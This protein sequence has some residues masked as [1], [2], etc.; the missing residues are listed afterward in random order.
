M[1]DTPISGL[2]ART[3]LTL[4]DEL[5]TLA[6]GINYRS[7]VSALI[8][9]MPTS[10]GGG[11]G[12][13]T[14]TASAYF[15]SI[16]AVLAAT[17]PATVKTIATSGYD[18][19]GV[20]GA[21]YQR[22]AT[23]P[24]LLAPPSNALAASAPSGGHYPSPH[25]LSGINRGILRSVDRFLPNGTSDPDKGGWWMLDLQQGLTPQMFGAW[26][27]YT[28]DDG[29]AIKDAHEFCWVARGND[30]STTTPVT[31]YIPLRFPV[32]RYNIA[33]TG[34][35][36]PLHDHMVW[37][38]EGTYGD[39]SSFVSQVRFSGNDMFV[40]TPPLTSP[41]RNYNDWVTFIGMG[42]DGKTQAFN[43]LRR[44][45]ITNPSDFI[46]FHSTFEKCGFKNF[47]YAFEALLSGVMI[48]YC[49]FQNCRCGLK[50]A[51]ADNIIEN[52]YMSGSNWDPVTGNSNSDTATLDPAG[53]DTFAVIFGSFRLSRFNRNYITGRPQMHLGVQGSLDGTIL[54]QNW[55]DI[56]DWSAVVLERSKGGVFIG[57]TFNNAML[58]DSAPLA[59]G[60][61][62]PPWPL[63]GPDMSKSHKRD[64]D[65][66]YNAII[67][68]TNNSH[69]HVFANNSFSYLQAVG[70]DKLPNG[71]HSPLTLK[72]TG[73]T[74]VSDGISHPGKSNNI[75]FVG[76]NFLSNY[77]FSMIY[78]T[79]SGP[80][81]IMERG[82]T[83]DTGHFPYQR[84]HA[85][86]YTD[87][88]APFGLVGAAG[89]PAG[90]GVFVGE[91]SGTGADITNITSW[92]VSNP[93][94]VR[95]QLGTTAA[96]FA[97]I[98]TGTNVIQFTG[99]EARCYFVFLE[100]I[101]SVPATNT[102]VLRLGFLD[103]VTGVPTDG[104]FFRYQ[105]GVN[106][107]KW[108]AVCLA[109]GAETVED[110]GIL[111]GSGNKIRRFQVLVDD[112][113]QWASFYNSDSLVAGIKAP[114]PG[115]ASPPAAMTNIPSGAGGRELGVGIGCVKLAGG[116]PTSPVD[117][118]M[119]EFEQRLL[120]QR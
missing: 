96:G 75:K 88:L 84:T 94:V 81:I 89:A 19:L 29:P 7:P 36:I 61:T 26:A 105:F 73:G 114:I 50:C 111:W 99:G 113:A 104:V 79:A 63:T 108:E 28:H 78:D 87:C 86:A 72:V 34:N 41:P 109:D 110:T 106:G 59:P 92:S 98:R 67:L 6:G 22:M 46:L 115:V 62:P 51:G 37:I 10:G 27:D 64:P 54:E 85:Y 35:P 40:I 31:S 102:F 39:E 60:E 24:A 42:F 30:L 49:F 119:I 16:A 83:G 80:P 38:G 77:K 47:N 93:G 15:D 118:D 9:L 12:G 5:T 43:F 100:N 82:G 65:G 44:V 18:K 11:G 117:V 53:A 48:R 58:A 68:I 91:V 116:A 112:T 71:T 55:F 120:S 74:G 101:I 13:G 90:N 17:I 95:L 2:P 33:G 69:H 3:S 32:G 56:C 97:G 107:D 25:P 103:S 14:T 21:I 45:N 1:P 4:T 20:G 66:I 76:N 8:P 70:S 57:N 23:A 52:N